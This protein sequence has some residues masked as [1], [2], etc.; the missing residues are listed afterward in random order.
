MRQS[1]DR[2]FAIAAGAMTKQDIRLMQSRVYNLPPEQARAIK[3]SERIDVPAD[4]N[5]GNK[6]MILCKSNKKEASAFN[7]LILGGI[8]GDGADSVAF[9]QF[10]CVLSLFKNI[11]IQL[12]I[13]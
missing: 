10:T 9:D 13:V 12:D 3:H 4:A 2:D 11:S 8:D 1:E 7:N 5:G 6:P